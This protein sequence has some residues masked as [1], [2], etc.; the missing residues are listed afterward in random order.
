MHV[1]YGGMDDQLRIL[2]PDGAIVACVFSG[3]VVDG[4]T[5]IGLRRSFSHHTT[6]ALRILKILVVWARSW[7]TRS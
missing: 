2:V 5:L 4:W 3:K 7:W 1:L 6:L